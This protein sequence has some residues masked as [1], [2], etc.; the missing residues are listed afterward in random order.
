[1]QRLKALPMCIGQRILKTKKKVAA[2]SSVS[3]N[4]SHSVVAIVIILKD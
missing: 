4:K 2:T 3:P 1:M